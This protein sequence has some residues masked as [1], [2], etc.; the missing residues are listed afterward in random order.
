MVTTNDDELA[1]QVRLLR[2]HGARPKYYHRMVGI[3][4]RL[5]AIQAA[6]LGVK[7][8]HLDD[9]SAAR[10][11]VADRYDDALADAP[12]I[13]TPYRSA[14]RTHIFHQYTIRILDDRRDAL[15]EQLKEK[16]IGT[17][18]YYPVPLHLQEC[19]VQLGYRQGELPQ[20][21]SA[22]NEVLSLPVYPELTVPEQDE[23]IRAVR[24]YLGPPSRGNGA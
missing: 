2:V 19:F 7:L 8:A 22:S 10:A 16:G 24:E 3:N 12:G 11:V 21:E 23:V 6:I 13:I 17:M 5:D 15:R 4:S 18:I 1:D 9:W 20:S 14:D